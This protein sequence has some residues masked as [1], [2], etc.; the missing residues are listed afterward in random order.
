MTTTEVKVVRFTATREQPCSSDCGGDVKVGSRG[1]YAPGAKV[2]CE[3]CCGG[4]DGG[5]PVKLCDCPDRKDGFTRRDDGR[6]VHAGCGQPAYLSGAELEAAEN[7][8]WVRG[9][10]SVLDKPETA[11]VAAP[12]VSPYPCP[13]SGSPLWCEC[14]G[15]GFCKGLPDSTKEPHDPAPTPDP[16]PP[17]AG[18][19]APAAKPKRKRARRQPRAGEPTRPVGS[20]VR[21]DQAA[22][23][24]EAGAAQGVDGRDQGGAGD[25]AA[26]GGNVDPADQPAPAQAAAVGGGDELA[27][28]RDHLQ[29]AGP[30]HVREVREAVD[31]VASRGGP[32]SVAKPDLGAFFAQSAPVSVAQ[33][34][35]N[36][37]TPFAEQYA[38]ELRGFV[39]QHANN[40]DRSLQKAL[41]P[42]EVGHSCH[43]M[44]AGKLAQL[45]AINHVGDPWASIVGTSLHA[46][47]A[48]CLLATNERLGRIRFLAEYRVTPAGFEGH[49]GTGDGYDADTESVIDHKALGDTSMGNLKQH[50][51]PRHY[52]VQTLLYARGFRA[53]GLP[54][55][56]VVLL[57]WPRTRST[58][59]AMYVWEHELTIE[60]DHFLDNVIAPELEY[61]KQWAVALLTGAAQLNDVPADTTDTCHFCPYYR[62]ASARDGLPGCPGHTTGQ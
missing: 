45:P 57:A 26:G 3:A 51:A 47:L 2:L 15:P 25:P 60:D 44:V 17:A 30:A 38:R 8:A 61:R 13:A 50:G 54:V 5:G 49:P 40:S 41:G 62:P 56:R 55:R 37:N 36:G 19:P 46:W 43:R 48:D 4:S 1:G 16:G 11:A 28:R 53:L 35:I 27:V 21:A 20:G 14:D 33:Q 29:D 12:T 39:E 32:I 34:R 18:D 7:E 42:S 9:E 24:G 58:L 23:G 52:L 10:T 6:Y 59:D 31:V 22:G